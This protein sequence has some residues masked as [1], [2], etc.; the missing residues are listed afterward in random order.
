VNVPCG[1]R[2]D[3]REEPLD[4]VQ[5]GRGRRREVA[6]EARVLGEPRLH[7][8]RLVGCVVVEHEMHGEMR[9]HGTVDLAQERQEFLWRGDAAS[10]RR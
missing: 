1:C 4:K 3:L 5:P 7:L 2:R 9:L 8:G 10:R 6:V